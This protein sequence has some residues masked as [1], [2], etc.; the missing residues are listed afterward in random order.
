MSNH[1]MMVFDR[2]IYR[3]NVAN[4]LGVETRGFDTADKYFSAQTVLKMLKSSV[5]R[6]YVV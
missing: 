6:R 3:N 2:W 4:K 5:T 1:R